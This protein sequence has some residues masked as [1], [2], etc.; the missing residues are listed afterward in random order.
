MLPEFL[1]TGAD[2]A[3]HLYAGSNIVTS[4]YIN[5][6]EGTNNK[7]ID[8]SNSTIDGYVPRNKKVLTYP[9]QYL[10]I[11]NNNGEKRCETNMEYTLTITTT[12][13]LP[14]TY[15]LYLNESE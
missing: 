4:R 8:L 15:K 12:T 6:E 5:G 10:L 11:S 9:Y 1:V 7:N 13:N 2:R 3:D 14:L